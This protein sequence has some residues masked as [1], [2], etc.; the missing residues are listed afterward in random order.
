MRKYEGVITAL[1]TPFINGAIDYKSLKKIIKLQVDAGVK[2]LVINGTTGES[3]TLSLEEKKNLFYFVKAEVSGKIPLIVGTGSNSTQST[4]E[5]TQNVERWG[6]D[7]ALVVVP[8]Y[9]KP[10]QRGLVQH[11]KTVAKNTNLPVILY[12]V[13]GRT[14]TSL[15]K[16]SILELAQEENIVGIKEASGKL[17]FAKVLIES[18]DSNFLLTSGDDG[19]FVDFV[20]LGGHGVISVFSNLA[21]QMTVSLYEMAMKKIDQVPAQ[22]SALEPLLKVLGSET[23]PIPI[24][25]ALNIKGIISSNEL[26]L[27]LVEAEAETIQK[28]KQ[29]LHQMGELK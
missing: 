8:Y 14:V 26:R 27:P 3:P 4:I 1:I 17:D 15:S 25:A 6:A 18:C 28:I 22:V 7:A 10:P 21:P 5:L 29:C 11:F 9:N 23:N 12:N 13:P 20:K 2:G 24:K 16:E 19:T